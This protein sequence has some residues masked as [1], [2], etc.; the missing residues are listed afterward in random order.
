MIR[1]KLP[2]SKKTISKSK[3]NFGKRTMCMVANRNIIGVWR[4]GRRGS[5]KSYW[6]QGRL[7][8]S[9]S[10]PTIYYNT[11]R[12]EGILCLKFM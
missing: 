6:P 11:F 4:N 8:S 10:I 2:P 1:S 5:L 9:P 12:N 7:G 3:Q